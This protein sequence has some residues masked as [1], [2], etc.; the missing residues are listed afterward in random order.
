MAYFIERVSVN[1]IEKH[2]DVKIIEE[3]SKEEIVRIEINSPHIG[4]IGKYSYLS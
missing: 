1:V 3:E 2:F 4:G